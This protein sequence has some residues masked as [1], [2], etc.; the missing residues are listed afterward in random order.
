MT[1]MPSHSIDD[2]LYE[3]VNTTGDLQHL[4]STVCFPRFHVGHPAGKEYTYVVTIYARFL[5]NHAQRSRPSLD[6]GTFLPF[7]LKAALS[8]IDRV[9]IVE[10]RQSCVDKHRSGRLAI[11]LGIPLTTPRPALIEI[12]LGQCRQQ[13]GHV[14]TTLTQH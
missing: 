11:P 5:S 13:S 12:R 1:P 14:L 9:T 4:T 6:R 10:H 7:L 3:H 8:V 2:A